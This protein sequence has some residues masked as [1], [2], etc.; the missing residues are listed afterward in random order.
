MVK[1]PKFLKIRVVEK[2]KELINVTIP[3]ALVRL[4]SEII[5]KEELEKLKNLGY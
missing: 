3:F 4:A 5:P 2:G 1:E